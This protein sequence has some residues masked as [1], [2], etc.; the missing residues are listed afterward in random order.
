MHVSA[1]NNKRRTTLTIPVK[2]LAAAERIAE[3]RKVNLSVIVSE[4][5]EEGLRAK[6][7]AA[8]EGQRRVQAWEAYCQSHA[9]LTD[10]E[11]L[12]L[13]GIIMEPMDEET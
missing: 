12:L 10:E 5:L 4:V 7:E 1:K 9:K 2:T 8:L 3:I 11:K 13:D 6:K